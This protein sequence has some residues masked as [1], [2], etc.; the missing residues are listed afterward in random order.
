MACVKRGDGLEGHRVDDGWVQL[1]GLGRQRL[2][3]VEIERKK[4]I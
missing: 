1:V 3:R 2:G 4:T